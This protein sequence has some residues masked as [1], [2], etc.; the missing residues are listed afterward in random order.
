MIEP[1]PCPARLLI[2]S[3]SDRHY[4]GNGTAGECTAEWDRERKCWR[5]ECS[6]QSDQPPIQAWADNQKAAILAVFAKW[7]GCEDE[8]KAAK[9]E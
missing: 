8:L 4:D 6:P 2:G 7:L 5:A 9:Y 1:R 3:F